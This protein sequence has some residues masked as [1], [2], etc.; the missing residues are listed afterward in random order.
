MKL[1]NREKPP[2]CGVLNCTAHPIGGI[3]PDHTAMARE[4]W[5]ALGIEGDFYSVVIKDGLGHTWARLI[6]TAKSLKED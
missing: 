4:L 2:F 1:A 6:D 3:V 5:E